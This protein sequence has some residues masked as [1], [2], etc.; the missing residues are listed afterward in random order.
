MGPNM[1][2]VCPHGDHHAIHKFQN[3]ERRDEMILYKRF[4]NSHGFF[5]FSW[6]FLELCSEIQFVIDCDTERCWLCRELYC[7]SL[8]HYILCR[9]SDNF[10]F[11]PR[12]FKTPLSNPFCNFFAIFLKMRQSFFYRV[13][14]W[15]MWGV[16]SVLFSFTFAFLEHFCS[17]KDK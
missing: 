9:F 16:V 15:N 4:Q 7:V 14:C 8:Q 2:Q 12:D 5:C 11:R 6:T 13:T 1:T 17:V 3:G 10:C